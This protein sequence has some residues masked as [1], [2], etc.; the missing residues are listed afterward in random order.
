MCESVTRYSQSW[1]TIDGGYCLPYHIAYQTLGLDA[2]PTKDTCI[3]SIK[4]ALGDSLNQDCTC[5]NT[6]QCRR[7][8]T[9]SCPPG[10][11]L[12]YPSSGSIISPYTYML[13]PWDGDWTQ[14]KPAL[15]GLRGRVKCLNYQFVMNAWF[16]VSIPRAFPII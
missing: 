9:K 12:L 3:M 6:V 2:T 13:Y 8:I 10:D 11:Y 5:K 16:I 15:L 14:K 7:L 1:W 4:C